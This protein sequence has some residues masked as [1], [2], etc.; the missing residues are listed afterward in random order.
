MGPGNTSKLKI[1]ADVKTHASIDGIF[2]LRTVFFFKKKNNV[3]K[4][5]DENAKCGW[6]FWTV[7]CVFVGDDSRT[8]AFLTIQ[9]ISPHLF[10]T[11]K[12]IHYR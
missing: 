5:Y 6:A 8:Q 12:V 4:K 11:G 7:V 10:Q 2:I 9:V 3:S 1:D